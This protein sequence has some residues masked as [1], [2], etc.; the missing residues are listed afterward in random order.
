MHCY[1]PAPI[2]TERFVE[3]ANQYGLRFNGVRS[4]RLSVMRR[5]VYPMKASP[6]APGSVPGQPLSASAS[7]MK[8]HGVQEWIDA[9]K[10]VHF[11]LSV[12]V[13]GNSAT[14]AGGT[15]TYSGFKFY[16]EIRD[17]SSTGP[18]LARAN[19]STVPDSVHTVSMNSFSAAGNPGYHM[20][21]SAVCCGRLAYP[22]G[23]SA[24]WHI[25]HYI[26][27]RTGY[28]LDTLNTDF[29]MTV[30]VWYV[31]DTTDRLM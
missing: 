31:V 21:Y 13:R 10:N 19:S 25:Q 22:I 7:I 20:Q 29:E 3:L 17:G 4:P 18:I 14:K 8:F 12:S 27:T 28:A 11:M 16:T 1:Q 5:T 9:M 30:S 26:D 23:E 2:S 15:F 24:Y 6:G